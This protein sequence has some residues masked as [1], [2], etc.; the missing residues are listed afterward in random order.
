MTDLWTTSH[1]VVFV[2]SGGQPVYY[3][4]VEIRNVM[5]GKV[6]ER[7]CP[8]CRRISVGRETCNGCGAPIERPSYIAMESTARLTCMMPFA[9]EL[10]CLK[11]GTQIDIL[12]KPCGRRNFYCESEVAVKL[13]N[14]SIINIAF[15]VLVTFA[16]NEAVIAHIDISCDIE[17]VTSRMEHSQ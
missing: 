10:L 3:G 17:I 16:D 15:P 13:L 1:S 5:R 9:S 4:C 8:Y 2:H 6:F 7:I 14:C 11:D 12:N